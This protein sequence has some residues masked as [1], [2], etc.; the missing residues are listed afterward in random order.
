[1]REQ[2][3]W[4]SGACAW[5]KSWVKSIHVETD[6]DWSVELSYEVDGLTDSEVS[7]ILLFDRFSLK[8]IDVSDPNIRQILKR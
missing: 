5:H 8:I 2:A 4:D 7:D 3:V 6:V 1:V